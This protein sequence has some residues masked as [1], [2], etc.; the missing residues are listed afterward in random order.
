MIIKSDN[1]SELEIKPISNIDNPI[2]ESN[3]Y[4]EKSIRIIN[5]LPTEFKVINQYSKIVALFNPLIFFMK[6]VMI[7]EIS[8]NDPVVYILLRKLRT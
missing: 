6:L 4:E 2:N 3:N 5:K 1:H 8:F 7:K